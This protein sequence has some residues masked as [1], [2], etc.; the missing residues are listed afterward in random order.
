MARIKSSIAAAA[1]FIGGIG[2]A[3]AQSQKAFREAV[4]AMG[5][6]IAASEFCSMPLSREVST[7]LDNLPA[8]A[9]NMAGIANGMERMRTQLES[10]ARRMG[11]ANACADLRLRMRNSNVGELLR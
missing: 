10:N 4:E 3:Q 1:I 5:S 9:P 6:L 8:S 11:R 7:F 2:A